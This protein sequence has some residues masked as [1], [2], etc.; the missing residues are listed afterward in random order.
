MRLLA[1]DLSSSPPTLNLEYVPGKTLQWQNKVLKFSPTE[2]LMVLEQ[3]LAALAYLHELNPPIIHRD[4]KPANILVQNRTADHIHT[5]L[6]DFGHSKD[7]YEL[8]TQCGTELYL[9]PEIQANAAVRRDNREPYTVAV[10][11]WS[12]GVMV[13]EFGFDLPDLR[14]AEGPAWCRAIVE[15][16]HRE[17]DSPT[18]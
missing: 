17:D 1:D 10:D 4:I 8:R 2:V 9:A 5:K 7:G 18:F 6:S 14:L 15:K 3:G 13:Y 11:I 16:L 12:L